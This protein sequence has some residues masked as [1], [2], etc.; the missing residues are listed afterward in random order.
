MDHYYSSKKKK[1]KERK[2]ERNHSHTLNGKAY[3]DMS[4]LQQSDS[5]FTSVLLF[6]DT[7]FDNNKNTFILD[8]TI[9]YITSTGRFDVHSFSSSWLAFVSLAL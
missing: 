8:A 9:D 2:R 5:K 7:W 3:I 1:K 6:R 4:V